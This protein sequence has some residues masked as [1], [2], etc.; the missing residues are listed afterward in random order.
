MSEVTAS[1]EWFLSEEFWDTFYPAMF[2]E[3]KFA[4]AG[5]EAAVLLEFSGEER[6]RVLDLACGPG[7]HAIPLAAFG[8]EVLGMDA[9][10]VLLKRAKERAER[11]SVKVQFE[12]AD[13]RELARE[14]AF[15]LAICMW[16]S[17]GYF[18]DPNEDYLVM[19]NMFEALVPGGTAVID[20]V[21]K[22]YMVRQIQPVHLTE[23]DDGRLLVERPVLTDE[24]TRFN[25]EWLLIDGDRVARHEF[26]HNLYSGQELRDRLESIGF[27]D[28]RLF[29]SLEGEEYDIDSERLIAVARRP[30]EG[31]ET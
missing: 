10:E 21:G 20:V 16:T 4:E 23:Y 29:G 28:V 25:N 5:R 27:R 15:D 17:L 3:E 13:M 19:A 31:A 24:M 18:D 30:L 9:S 11:A 22:E 1:Q 8:C 26:A 12:H 7:R 6:P 2:T 14:K